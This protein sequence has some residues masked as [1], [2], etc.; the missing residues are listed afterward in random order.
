MKKSTA[1]DE[2]PKYIFDFEY[3]AQLQAQL[4]AETA[5]LDRARHEQHR[6]DLLTVGEIREVEALKTLRR[7]PDPVQQGNPAWWRK[8]EAWLNSHP[9]KPDALD[10][11]IEAAKHPERWVQVMPEPVK[12]KRGQHMRGRKQSTETRAKIAEATRRRWEENRDQM[13]EA[14]KT[15]HQTRRDYEAAKR[16]WK[17]APY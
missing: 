5:R 4:D 11:M 14:T 12:L 16:E 15:G 3:E 8:F 1:P 7:L 6:H 17:K 13:L 2:A 10:A 9:Y